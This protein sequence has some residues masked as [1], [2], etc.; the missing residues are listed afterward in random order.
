MKCT[1]FILYCDS[2]EGQTNEETDRGC[3]FLPATEALYSRRPISVQRYE[4]LS[5]WPRSFTTV[6]ECGQRVSLMSFAPQQQH[7]IKRRSRDL[8]IQELEA[9]CCISH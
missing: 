2:S 3:C 5:D 8:W 7:A 4:L 6:M 9:R 1:V